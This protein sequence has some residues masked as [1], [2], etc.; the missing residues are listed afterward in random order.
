MTAP[1]ERFPTSS[2]RLRPRQLWDRPHFPRATCR[3]FTRSDCIVFF[4]GCAAA[5]LGIAAPELT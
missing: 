5:R 2:A 4:S 3:R 1:P